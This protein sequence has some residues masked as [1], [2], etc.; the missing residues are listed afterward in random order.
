MPVTGLPAAV[1]S[2]LNTL[3]DTN[4]VTSWKITGESNSSVVIIRLSQHD[5]DDVTDINSRRQ[6]HTWR[7]KP[8]AQVRRDADRARK[9][10]R[11]V[12]LCDNDICNEI[13][14]DSVVD[15]NASSETSNRPTQL[16]TNTSN[17][18]TALPPD[19]RASRS[20]VP[21]SSKQTHGSVN[22]TATVHRPTTTKMQE[23]A[24]AEAKALE[25]DYNVENVKDTLLLL[26]PELKRKIADQRRNRRLNNIV[27]FS[28][29]GKEQLI[30]ESDDFIFC[31]DCESATTLNYAFKGDPNEMTEEELQWMTRLQ[32]Q[33]PIS[34]SR[35]RA[36]CDH[37]TEDLQALADLARCCLT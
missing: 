19:A 35:H 17:D 22:N 4:H 5:T 1:E 8:P 16:S 10:R 36:E 2:A 26:R 23:C 27:T 18:T 9:W 30:A 29:R 13:G 12:G 21:A 28:S 3:L 33:Q 6:T 37:I 31:Y 20:E 24:R 25:R 14:Q 11:E 7:K 15:H 34:R 32:C